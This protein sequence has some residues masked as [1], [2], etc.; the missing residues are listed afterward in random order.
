MSEQKDEES[1]RL[2]TITT[3]DHTH[4]THKSIVK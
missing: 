4:R 3:E 2:S 1:K